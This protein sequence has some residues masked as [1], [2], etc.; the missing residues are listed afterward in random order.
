MRCAATAGGARCILEEGH[1]P[2][3]PYVHKWLPNVEGNHAAF[4][5]RSAAEELTARLGIPCTDVAVPD[6]FEK[7]VDV[8]I[9]EIG[10]A[11]FGSAVISVQPDP[12][13]CLVP[14]YDGEDPPR[15]DLRYGH[16]SSFHRA[17]FNGRRM[18]WPIGD[19]EAAIAERPAEIRPRAQDDT[20]DVTCAQA[21]ESPEASASYAA[22]RLTGAA[23]NAR[24]RVLAAV[25]GFLRAS[26]RGW[27]RLEANDT[28]RPPS[29]YD[30][31][32]TEAEGIAFTEGVL[33][34]KKL[35]DAQLTELFQIIGGAL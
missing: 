27:T 32:A 24:D 25:L 34:A 2:W 19:A 16:R 5:A 13:R 31:P 26:E 33:E 3:P 12:P 10:D 14:M 11:L 30:R 29:K 18:A 1:E 8:D 15:C 7:P 28:G 6:G 22:G 9:G 17:T 4:L 35:H 23:N 20:G 21:D